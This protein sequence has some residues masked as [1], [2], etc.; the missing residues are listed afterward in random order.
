VPAI[1]NCGAAVNAAPAAIPVRRNL[2]LLNSLWFILFPPLKKLSE[3][4]RVLRFLQC[5][6][7][8]V[9][10]SHADACAVALIFW[11]CRFTPH[12]SSPQIELNKTYTKTKLASILALV[13][14]C[15]Q[16]VESL[17]SVMTAVVMLLL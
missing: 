15:S 10:R 5:T 8:Q 1:A 16:R 4:Q 7:L 9:V 13:F 14:P 11:D 6:G 17:N 2:R 3:R 12:L